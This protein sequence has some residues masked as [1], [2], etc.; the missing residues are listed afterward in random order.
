MSK[1]IPTNQELNAVTQEL[2][3]A[4]RQAHNSS[5]SAQAVVAQVEAEINT[6][7]ANYNQALAQVKA[8]QDEMQSLKLQNTLSTL[9]K[10]QRELELQKQE[11]E[12]QLSANNA[13]KS[14]FDSFLKQTN[15]A[16]ACFRHIE[17]IPIHTNVVTLLPPEELV[18]AETLKNAIKEVQVEKFYNVLSKIRNEDI[19]YQ[20]SDG[21]KTLLIH[22]AMNGFYPGVNALLARGANAD[23]LDN[24]GANALIYFAN[25]PYISSFKQLANKTSNINN[26]AGGLNNMTAMH[27]LVA[28]TNNKLF[29]EEVQE[30]S[31]N[32]NVFFNGILVLSPNTTIH[33]DV[34]DGYDTNGYSQQQEKTYLLLKHLIGRS[35]DLSSQDGQGRTPFLYACIMKLKYLTREII[36]LPEFTVGHADN[37]GYTELHWSLRLR[38]VGLTNQVLQKDSSLLRAR[39]I[40]G[41]T[42]LHISAGGGDS[43]TFS[44]LLEKDVTLLN[45]KSKLGITPLMRAANSVFSA[46]LTI[47][48]KKEAAMIVQNALNTKIQYLD[49]SIVDNSGY[50]IL[51][52]AIEFFRVDEERALNITDRIIAAMPSLIHRPDNQGLTTLFYVEKYMF[53]GLRVFD[54]AAELLLCKGARFVKI[55]GFIDDPL[56]F[57]CFFGLSK[58][59]VQILSTY[60]K[61]YVENSIY[62][63]YGGNLLYWAAATCNADFV[64]ALIQ[65]A[66]S[67]LFTRNSNP[68]HGK[69][70]TVLMHAVL[71][72]KL[73]VVKLLLDRGALQGNIDIIINMCCENIMHLAKSVKVVEA[74]V[75]KMNDNGYANK[76]HTLLSHQDTQGNTPL[77]C[78]ISAKNYALAKKFADCD[79]K[80]VDIK[81]SGKTPLCI[82]LEQ[83]EWP[84]E[85]RSEINALLSVFKGHTSN[86][87]G[88][89]NDAAYI[90]HIH[91]HDDA[92]QLLG[93]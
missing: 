23:L 44:F 47:E 58:A 25:L 18:R 11:Y 70:N 53:S 12:A 83:D 24:K 29:S 49:L 88:F 56:W 87:N 76:V 69:N 30:L 46:D 15:E 64:D 54:K 48:Q 32:T 55:Q 26:K 37:D 50:S 20:Y 19:N 91:N 67:L 35:G 39:D 89:N 3:S 59:G 52:W 73:E 7:Q 36:Q 13:Q 61:S 93:I 85:S 14:L 80:A 10:E 43:K 8:K 78:A 28:G 68:E 74:I 84:Q 33:G 38:D 82:L 81:A 4:S 42:C 75:K 5:T 2:A 60:D 27:A 1:T 90:A 65:K 72:D 22:A 66:P 31:H 45:D 71:K 77:H 86:I 21:S 16:L 40:D 63:T 34:S 62:E 9:Q 57:S 92:M 17:K 79:Q 41:M 51:G 6:L